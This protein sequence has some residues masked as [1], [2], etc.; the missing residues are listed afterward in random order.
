MNTTTATPCPAC[1][2][3][4]GWAHSDES[5]RKEP[6]DVC[7]S[8]LG[9]GVDQATRCHACGH[10]ADEHI[11]GR[12][13][14]YVCDCDAVT[15]STPAPARPAAVREFADELAVIVHHLGQPNPTPEDWA[16]VRQAAYTIMRVT[17]EHAPHACAMLTHH[18]G[19][20]LARYADAHAHAL[21]LG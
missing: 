5:R 19:H 3:H 13:E 21:A 14:C 4:R 9:S 1:L 2:P 16:T 12:R 6:R 18:N 17:G 10:D 11:N 8:C 15:T 20:L 7:R